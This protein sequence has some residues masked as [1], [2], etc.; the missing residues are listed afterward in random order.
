MRSPETDE[1][2]RKMMMRCIALSVESGEKGEYPYGVVIRRASEIASES[3]T[4]PVETM[5]ARQQDKSC[6][7]WMRRLI[8]FLRATVFDCFGRR[9]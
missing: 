3:I 1:L 7:T 6:A 4:G 9:R 5:H 8:P 2:D